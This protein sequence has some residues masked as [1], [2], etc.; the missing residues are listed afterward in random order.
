MRAYPPRCRSR[1]YGYWRFSLS[2]LSTIHLG[3]EKAFFFLSQ[4][5]KRLR[6]TDELDVYLLFIFEYSGAYVLPVHVVFVNVCTLFPSLVR[7]IADTRSYKHI[8]T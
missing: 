7:T 4:K 8:Y 6:L 3:K 5:L 1:V 2:P